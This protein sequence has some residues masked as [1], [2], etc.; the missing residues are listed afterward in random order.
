MNWPGPGGPYR[1]ALHRDVYRPGE[2]TMLLARA[3][4][5]VGQDGERF[6]EVGCGSGAVSLVAARKGMV[7]HATDLNPEAVR[8]AKR[9][10]QQNDV[11]VVVRQGDLDAGH[12]GPFDLVAFNPPYLPTAPEERLPGP[13]NLAFDGGLTGNDTVMRFVDELV[14]KH[15]PGKVLVVHS[16]LA[17]AAPLVARMESLGYGH[18]LWA[19]EK[20]AFES[21]TVR[22]F[23][24]ASIRRGA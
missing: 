19:T 11:D 4:W 24:A 18:R 14:A 10:A 6:L 1:I 5:D 22:A 9:N 7:A 20:H 2:D 13:I 8:L 16:S 3:V 23:H 12:A 17:D 15:R 21:V